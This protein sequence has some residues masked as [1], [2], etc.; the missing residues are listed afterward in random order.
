MAAR[1]SVPV[2]GMQGSPYLQPGEWQFNFGYRYMKSDRHFTGVNE[3]PER[4][5]EH[6][7][8]IN[9]VH[10]MDFALT[11]QVTKRL[12]LSFSLPVQIATRSSPI[13]DANRDVVDRDTQRADGIG[14]MA[15]TSKIW[16]LNPDE[17]PEG[18]IGV[19]LGVKFPTGDTDIRHQTIIRQGNNYTYQERTVD[20]SI[21]PGDGGFGAILNLETFKVIF[22]K[23]TLFAYGTYLFNPRST[24]GTPTFRSGSGEEEMSVADQYLAKAGVATPIPF[25][26]KYGFSFTIAGRIEGVPVRDLIGDSDGF[27]RP[28]YAISVEPGLV[29]LYKRHTLGLSA[30]IALYRDR[31]KSVPDEHASPER[32]GDAAFADYLILFSYSYA[33]GGSPEHQHDNRQNEPVVPDITL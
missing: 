22:E 13:R 20:Q 14:D 27:R 21:T 5:A 3:E 31:Q 19:G 18:N 4:Q 30:P 24:N 23:Y 8:V 17:N 9:E 1:Q 2:L 10:L 15:L 11:R 12:S 32:H 28:G 26:S 25:L 6:S 16:L 33:F 7:E 29:W